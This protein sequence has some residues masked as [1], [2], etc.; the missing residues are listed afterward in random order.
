ML[1]LG[2]LGNP[3]EAGI[4]CSQQSGSQSGF[5]RLVPLSSPLLDL[6][7]VENPDFRTGQP[8]KPPLL[9]CGELRAH[10]SEEV[11]GRCQ[12]SGWGQR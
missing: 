10:D 12:G 9:P 4:I 2:G 6:P 8:Y 3:Q 1:G 7:V 11:T 5:E